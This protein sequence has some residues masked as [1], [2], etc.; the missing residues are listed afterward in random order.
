MKKLV[1]LLVLMMAFSGC[2]KEADPVLE[3]VADE[4]VPVAAEPEPVFVW[5]PSD[6]AA[7]ASAGE[8]ECYTWGECELRIQTLDGGDIAKTMQTLTG[9]SADRLTVMEY[10]KDGL[11][12]YQTVWSTTGEDGIFLGRA[13][14]ADD[15]NFHYC[16]S[17]LSPEQTDV[18][19]DYAQ[20]CASFSFTQEGAAK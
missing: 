12:I 2:G 1:W 9:L 18:A 17:L 7:Q 11:Q 13:M 6:A 3:T 4:I 15:G 19:E 8:G 10:E 20:I 14:V 16:V 5:M